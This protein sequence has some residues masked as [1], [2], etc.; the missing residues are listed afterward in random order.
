[1]HSHNMAVKKDSTKQQLSH[2]VR[3]CVSSFF[4]LRVRCVI[5]SY[6][7]QQYAFSSEYCS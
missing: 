5:F 6:A 2:C 4:P 3:I 1:M 7:R